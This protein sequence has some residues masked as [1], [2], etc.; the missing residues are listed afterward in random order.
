M[1][2]SDSV[3]EI[4]SSHAARREDESLTLVFL[5]LA[6]HSAAVGFGAACLSISLIGLIIRFRSPEFL[7]ERERGI[8]VARCGR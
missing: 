5:L 3:C 6:I 1:F 2:T 4:S 8:C 7:D